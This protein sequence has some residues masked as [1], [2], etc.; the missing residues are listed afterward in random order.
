MATSP[1]FL[2]LQSHVPYYM[3]LPITAAKFFCWFLCNISS[4]C[5]HFSH[6]GLIFFYKISD[7]WMT[8]SFLN[9]FSASL[10]DS[11][12]C[13]QKLL[14]FFF[15][16]LFSDLWLNK[17]EHLGS[18]NLS[19]RSI[20]PCQFLFLIKSFVSD[21]TPGR[22]PVCMFPFLKCSFSDFILAYVFNLNELFCLT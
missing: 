11:S 12:G 4:T 9:L 6:P 10:V 8:M 7:Y 20:L 3:P 2:R 15:A 19:Q 17:C 22:G 5:P 18:L 16:H 13:T 1:F 21:P 14:S